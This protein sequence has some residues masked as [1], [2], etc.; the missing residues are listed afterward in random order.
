MMTGPEGIVEGSD[1]GP[2][3]S[4]P[5]RDDPPFLAPV[6]EGGAGFGRVGDL[7]AVEPCGQIGPVGHPAESLAVAGMVIE[8]RL[9]GVTRPARRL[10][11][12]EF[13]ITER[14]GVAAGPFG[15]SMADP[16][17]ARQD[18]RDA[19]TGDDEP[20]TQSRRGIG[21][22]GRHAAFADWF[23]LGQEFDPV[24]CGGDLAGGDEAPDERPSY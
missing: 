11:G 13:L 18:Q 9:A 21:C 12:E 1:V 15:R 22:R 2:A 16:Y 8:G 24:V 14:R 6:L 7:L 4:G 3:R 19:E 23:A 17:G 5:V 20:P 10:A